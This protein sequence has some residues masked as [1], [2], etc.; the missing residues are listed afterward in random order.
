[1]L[2]IHSKCGRLLPVF[3]AILGWCLI[4]GQ[5]WGGGEYHRPE[6][7]RCKTAREVPTHSGESPN[8]T[9]APGFKR[10]AFTFARIRRDRISFSGYRS[11]A[12]F[13]WTDFP[14]S[15]LNLSYRLQQM[16]S[17]KVDPDGRVLDITDPALFGYPWIYM[18]EVG[19]LLLKDEEVPILRKYLLNGG[20]LMAD[21]FW[22]EH[23]WEVFE[24][25][26]KRVLPDFHF[27]ELP[28]D[29]PVFSSVF[30]V[31]RERNKLQVPNVRTGVMSEQTGITYE[32]HDGEPCT[33]V[34]IR[35]IF[36]QKG[37][38]M[39]IAMH[40]TDNGDGWE[41]EGENDYYFHNFSENI[42]FPLGINII[43][44]SMTH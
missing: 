29:H 19:S 18:V 5:Y 17:M 15:D 2:S 28:M 35:G 10:D 33:E 42:A 11:R 21:D 20:F 14:D 3:F 9:N 43:F 1:M 32:V 41:R 34:H 25:Q 4:H 26:I 38:L 7:D 23:Q 36:D 30:D 40:N 27:Q 6:Y 37:R 13:W 31:R 8:W 12:G 24:T 16:T 39:V 22:G 44:Y